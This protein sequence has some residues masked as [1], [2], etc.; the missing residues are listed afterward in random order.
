MN[1]IQPYLR[2]ATRW[3][4]TLAY[5]FAAAILL[6]HE[7]ILPACLLLVYPHIVDGVLRWN[8][9]SNKVVQRSMMIDA[10]I[11]GQLFS[12]IEF[13]LIGCAVLLTLL[14]VSTLVIAGLF[15]LILGMMLMVVS[16]ALGFVFSSEYS[17]SL[18]L[19]ILSLN[20]VDLISLVALV[21]YLAVISYLIFRETR[22]L[23]HRRRTESWLRRNLERLQLRV[24]PFLAPQV[25]VRERNDETGTG[26]KRLTVFFSDIEGFTKLMDEGDEQ[27]V[28]KRLN[29]Y[30]Q[31]MTRIAAI[32]GGTIDKFMGDGVMIFF[33]D[34][35]TNG[36]AADAF[37]CVSM[38]LE[39]RASVYRLSECWD[40]PIRI[41]MGIHT[42]YCLV[43]NFGSE[44]RMDYTA[45]G[46]VVNLASRLESSAR[47]DEILVSA[48]TFKLVSPWVAARKRGSISV[49]GVSRPVCTYSI[50]SARGSGSKRYLPGNL[51]LLSARQN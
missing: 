15:Y 51:K 37:A 50:L 46:S 28:A 9:S 1:L 14:V 3:P 11:V 43:G 17:V 20:I 45:V 7:I 19:N 22:R 25:L 35:V 5:V 4:R 18:S 42:G 49:K 34:P 13:D 21:S 23:D 10:I 2:D 44:S 39:M 32:H 47:S 29:E 31:E 41:R 30:L 38:A 24:K 26:R 8:D 12:L 16:A 48:D 6:A 27:L 36:A 40:D 33:G